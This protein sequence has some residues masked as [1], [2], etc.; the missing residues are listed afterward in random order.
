[1][2]FLVDA[3]LPKK[4]A[5]FLKELGHDVI[6]TSELPKRNQTT[7]SAISKVSISQKRIVV[8][9]DNDF[10]DSFVVKSEPYKLLLIATGNIRNDELIE[11]VKGNLDELTDEF[12]R[13][14]VIELNRD[15]IIVHF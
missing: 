11:I 2:R 8:T 3:Q 7:D 13:S 12:K 5:D 6:H 1:M 4:L 15:S 10:L 14:H 9:K